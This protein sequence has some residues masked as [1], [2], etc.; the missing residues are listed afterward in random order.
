MN[1][2]RRRFFRQVGAIGLAG[3][4]LPQARASDDHAIAD[5]G[6][7][8]LVD[9]TLCNGCR[10]CEAACSK[11]AGFGSLSEEDIRDREVFATH[12]RPG[13]K[14]Y[15]VV[16]AFPNG[17]TAEDPEA[18]HNIYAKANCLHCLKP[19]CVSGC[20]V[21][22]LQRD[23][24]GAVLYDARKCMG[25]RYCMVACPFHIPAYEYDNVFTP[26]VRKCTF[27]RDEGNPHR[28]GPP[29]CVKICP[30]EC[31]TYGKRSELLIRAHAKINEHPDRYLPHV[32]GEHEAGGTAWMY[33]SRVP[34]EKLNFLTVPLRATPQ[35]TESIQH[36]IFKHFVP[37]VAWC[38]ILALAMALT[39]PEKEGKDK[40]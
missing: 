19:A 17:Q 21:G 34:F 7:G 24:T 26:Q 32:Y 14:S 2:S 23:E 9:L 29:A 4:A 38:G 36:G 15:T 5:D 25:C 27:C 30:K 35:L 6:M 1:V 20:I 31:M 11:T 28:D 40:S 37:P 16:N 10:S 3:A 39:R 22:A 12:R 8:V 13:P 33:L 18:D